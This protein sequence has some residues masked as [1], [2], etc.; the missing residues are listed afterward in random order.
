MTLDVAMM[1]MFLLIAPF[2]AHMAAIDGDNWRPRPT[3]L[4]KGR[5]GKAIVR[6][7][8]LI[9]AANGIFLSCIY[10]AWELAGTPY[11]YIPILLSLPTVL[12]QFALAG[13]SGRQS[14]GR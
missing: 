3:G 4:L 6:H 5:V 11:L 9:L 1:A 8:N 13:E 7:M 14:S 12:A 10:L 2:V